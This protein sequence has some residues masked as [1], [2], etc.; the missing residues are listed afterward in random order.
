MSFVVIIGCGGREH[1]IAKSLKKNSNIKLIT[2]G[3][4]KNPGLRKISDFYIC[5]DLTNNFEIYSSI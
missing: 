1:A 5:L 3:N 4:F 2:I